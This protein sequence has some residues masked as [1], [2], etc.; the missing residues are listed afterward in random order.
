MN[1]RGE[2]R[3]GTAAAV[4]RRQRL[5]TR[6]GV[7]KRG[8][9]VRCGPDDSALRIRQLAHSE[10]VGVADISMGG[11]QIVVLSDGATGWAPVRALGAVKRAQS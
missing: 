8:A 4:G 3:T 7:L 11:W 5:S 1:V 2:I 6:P 10:R 9:D